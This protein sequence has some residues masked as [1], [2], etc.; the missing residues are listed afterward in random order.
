MLV[1]WTQTATDDLTQICDY[2]LDQFGPTQPAALRSQFTR[3]RNPYVRFLTVAGLAACE[4][5][6]S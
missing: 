1:R 3:A 5:P 4:T 6:A 2:T